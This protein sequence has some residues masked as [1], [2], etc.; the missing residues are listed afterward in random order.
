[1]TS[2][3]TVR[4][5]WFGLATDADQKT[6]YWSGGGTNVIHRFDLTAGRL[7]IGP[8]EPDQ[9]KL[10]KEEKTKL[11]NFR[12]GLCLDANAGI[13]YTLDIDQGVRR[14]LAR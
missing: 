1:M 10:T 14:P 11:A 3:V 4:Q 7:P 5:S 8:P 2:R 6:I 13:L 9:A 12:S